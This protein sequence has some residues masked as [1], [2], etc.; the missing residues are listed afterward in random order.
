MAGTAMLTIEA[1]EHFTTGSPLPT[2]SVA[3]VA[4]IVELPCTTSDV[5]TPSVGGEA[6]TST[7]VNSKR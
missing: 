3:E 5:L 1:D 2:T 4:T 6:V 7:F